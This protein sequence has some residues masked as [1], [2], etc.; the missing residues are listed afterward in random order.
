MDYETVVKEDDSLEKGDK[1]VIREGQN[2][3]KEV[4]TKV[5]LKMEKKK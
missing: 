2:G 5:V 4:T 3:E 1:K